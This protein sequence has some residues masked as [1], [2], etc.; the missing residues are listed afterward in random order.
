MRCRR[1]ARFT[2][3]LFCSFGGNRRFL[4]LQRL[5]ILALLPCPD[6]LDLRVRQ[7][8]GTCEVMTDLSHFFC[9]CIAL[10]CLPKSVTYVIFFPCLG[11]ALFH[12][13]N[14]IFA[15]VK[16]QVVWH[17]SFTLS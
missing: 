9:C 15:S 6:C 12:S 10:Y 1:C 13:E 17:C 2:Y 3:S 8:Q 16:N 5:S 11:I 7:S 4:Q 14:H